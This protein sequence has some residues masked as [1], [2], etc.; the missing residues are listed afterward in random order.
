MWH[1]FPTHLRVE[2]FHVVRKNHVHFYTYTWA[3]HKVEWNFRDV[4]PFSETFFFQIPVVY[5]EDGNRIPR[6]GG[7]RSTGRG[8]LVLSPRAFAAKNRATNNEYSCSPVG[9]FPPC[10]HYLYYIRSPPRWKGKPRIVVRLLNS[11]CFILKPCLLLERVWTFRVLIK[12][13]FLNLRGL[14]TKLFH[15]QRDFSRNKGT[16]RDSPLSIIS[17]A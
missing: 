3:T 12:V 9:E 4:Q 13:I 8:P 2:L 15:K 6:A 14:K 1:S 17:A 10:R 16:K 11:I 5:H 7:A